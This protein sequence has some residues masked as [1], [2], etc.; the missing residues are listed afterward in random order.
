MCNEISMQVMKQQITLQNHQFPSVQPTI[1]PLLHTATAL[2]F[3]RFFVICFDENDFVMTN[4]VCLFVQILQ[5]IF[6]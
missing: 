6:R 3:C 4:T 1:S 5:R 2:S